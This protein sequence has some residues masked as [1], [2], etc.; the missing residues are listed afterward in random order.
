MKILII[1][2]TV[3]LLIVILYGWI[4]ADQHFQNVS[5]QI[6]QTLTVSP[7]SMSIPQ[8]YMPVSTLP[9]VNDL[10]SSLMNQGE[11]ILLQV[12][13][14]CQIDVDNLK[15]MFNRLNELMQQNNGDLHVLTNDE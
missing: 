11:E 1:V 9:Q 12:K 14:D 5:P 6:D 15:N 13:N 4:Y 3:I 7:S 8:N 10:S 2:L